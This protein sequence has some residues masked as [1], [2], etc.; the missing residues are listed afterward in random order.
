MT[1]E[2]WRLPLNVCYEE[3]LSY[4]ETAAVEVRLSLNEWL[5]AHILCVCYTT[6]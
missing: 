3:Q 2:S 6:V 4:E 1:A 5:A